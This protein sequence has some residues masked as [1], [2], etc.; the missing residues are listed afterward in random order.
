MS[1]QAR[2]LV[3]E[4][5]ALAAAARAEFRD[6]R[7]DGVQMDDT[8]RGVLDEGEGLVATGDGSVTYSSVEDGRIAQGRLAVTTARLIA[9]GPPAVTI[10]PLDDMDDVIVATGQLHVTVIGGSG[11]TI[12]T[13]YPRLLRVQLAE[14]RARRADGQTGRPVEPEADD[15]RR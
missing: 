5:E 9:V 15:S 3:A 11:F 12:E 6:R 14:A 4:D 1:R 8:L 7:C 2:D 10:A 13:P